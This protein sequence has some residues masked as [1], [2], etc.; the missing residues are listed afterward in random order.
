M[1]AFPGRLTSAAIVAMS[2]DELLA[3][4]F[5]SHIRYLELDAVERKTKGAKY[6]FL[7]ASEALMNAW[8]QWGRLQRAAAF[9]ELTPRR[10]PKA[11]ADPQLAPVS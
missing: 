10:V 11:G 8:D 2:E 4:E 9:R 6:S 3:A 5:E 1:V 7:H